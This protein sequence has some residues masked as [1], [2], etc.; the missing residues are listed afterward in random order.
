MAQRAFHT[1]HFI[2]TATQLLLAIFASSCGAPPLED[3]ESADQT[4]TPIEIVS[5]DYSGT[6]VT[7]TAYVS[8]SSCTSNSTYNSS[9]PSPVALSTVSLIVNDSCTFNF[10]RLVVSGTTYYGITSY[11][12]LNSSTSAVLRFSSTQ[13]GSTPAIYVNAKTT[14]V[15]PVGSSPS[16]TFTVMTESQFAS[17][18]ASGAFSTVNTSSSSGN[19]GVGAI[20]ASVRSNFLPVGGIQTYNATSTNADG[21][22]NAAA[23]TWSSSNTGVATIDSTTG[24]ATGV[25]VGHAQ[26]IATIT[27]SLGNHSTS[28][29]LTVKT[30]YL[31]V[32]A[33]GSMYRCSLTNAG[34]VTCTSLF[35]SLPGG[36]SGYLRSAIAY[37]NYIYI[38]DQGED[39]LYFTPVNID[40]TDLRV[41]TWS[42]ATT[43]S[44]VGSAAIS[45]T[46]AFIV[47]YSVS[48]IQ[49]CSFNTSTG[50]MSSCTTVKSGLNGASYLTIATI[51][52]RDYLVISNRGADAII[53]CS[54]TSGSTTLSSCGASTT[55]AAYDDPSAL[56]VIGNTLYISSGVYGNKLNIARCTIG[57]DLTIS[58]CSV[59]VPTGKLTKGPNG[60]AVNGNYMYVSEFNSN[61]SNKYNLWSCDMTTWVSNSW[62]CTLQ[63]NTLNVVPRGLLVY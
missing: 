12:T 22:A 59:V 46:V 27:D 9:A 39:T 60:I 43:L 55:N 6:V 26:I 49:G 54:I 16:F 8:I 57:T 14:N 44:S 36:S 42:T 47:G 24:V 11:M 51:S 2:A 33:Y 53:V 5:S 58:S 7:A 28:V 1:K 23:V 32:T 62:V 34:G 52:G 38:A 29:G 40:G 35:A 21:S 61:A 20:S 18:V 10:Q 17:A 41:K 30:P 37:Q 63:V 19:M 56:V 50:I 25:G 3:I 45:G 48:S 31:Y 4:T 15:Y 13:G